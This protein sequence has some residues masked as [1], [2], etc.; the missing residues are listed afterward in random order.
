MISLIES[1]PKISL[2]L[3]EVVKINCA[4]NTYSDV[5]LFWTQD[6]DKAVISMLDGNMTIY[7]NAADIDELKQFI[8]VIAPQSIFSDA[9]TLT[10]LFGT[11][12][13]RVFVMQSENN[14]ECKTQS[15]NLKSDEIYNLL[16]VP[17]L[18]LPPFEYFAVDF[19]RR[20]NRGELKYFAIK[21]KCAAVAVCDG[22]TALVNGIASHQKGSG[23]LA[24]EGLLSQYKTAIIAVCQKEVMPFYIKNKFYHSYDAGYWRKNT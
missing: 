10:A 9:K 1:I 2:P 15:D 12:F 4:Y 17:E 16:N 3:A 13:Q 19:C 11:Q 6:K 22:Y 7:N 5:A 18:E 8:N 14:F 21:D 24:L 20:L 23:S